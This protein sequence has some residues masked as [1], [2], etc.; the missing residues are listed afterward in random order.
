MDRQAEDLKLRTKR[1]AVKVLDFVDML[2][3]STA[4]RELGRQ[5]ARSGLGTAGNYRG[6]CRGRSHA[7]FTARLGVVLEE[8][9]ESELWLDMTEEKQWGGQQLREW[10]LNESRELRAIFSKGCETA[11]KR[12]YTTK[13]R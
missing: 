7:E 13:A 10:L 3:T 9:D 4:G 5:L 2:P 6:A 1:F 8:V 12:E 11:R